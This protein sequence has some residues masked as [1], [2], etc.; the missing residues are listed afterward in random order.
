MSNGELIKV[1]S[2]VVIVLALAY[3]RTAF[4]G[5]HMTATT[6]SFAFLATTPSARPV[7]FDP[8]QP[9]HYVVNPTGMPN[10]GMEL[11]RD[12]IRTISAA[13][14]L[15][16]IADGFTYER[17]NPR[18]RPLVQPQR[19]G[20]GWAPVLIAWVNQRE[21]PLVRG[22]IVGAA[23]SELI[24]QD[25]PES[26]RYVTGQIVFD[27]EDF[28][29]VLPGD[30]GYVEARAVVIHELGHLVGLDHVDDPG[31]LMARDNMGQL[32][33]GPGDRQGLSEAGKGPCWP[34][35]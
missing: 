7:T 8:C 28:A 32:E 21:S 9:I 33:L 16:F 4:P 6:G 31:E 29:A 10:G 15:T 24:A 12:G 35:T 19:Y 13:T 1:L 3:V 26:A 25:G 23:H 17:P 11:I 30:D 5:P 2:I 27:R 20:E 22:D 18:N 34:A 14:G